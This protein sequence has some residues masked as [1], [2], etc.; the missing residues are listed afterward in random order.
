MSPNLPDVSFGA[1]RRVPCAGS[2]CLSFGLKLETAAYHFPLFASFTSMLIHSSPAL[3]LALSH[4]PRSA[5]LMAI[6]A[7]TKS[8]ALGCG[9]F[10]KRPSTNSISSLA[11]GDL[12][13]VLFGNLL[14]AV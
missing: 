10:T 1:W 8:G 6:W 3:C 9:G 11:I 7:F 4:T 12:L 14:D 13:L 2:S 5:T